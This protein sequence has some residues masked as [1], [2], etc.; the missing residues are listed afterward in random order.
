MSGRANLQ[1]TTGIPWLLLRYFLD[2]NDLCRCYCC[3]PPQLSPWHADAAVFQFQRSQIF[4][5]WL[6]SLKAK[7]RMHRCKY[8]S[9]KFRRFLFA[10]PATRN[11]LAPCISEFGSGV[12]RC[13]HFSTVCIPNYISWWSHRWPGHPWS[14]LAHHLHH[15]YHYPC[16]VYVYCA[17]SEWQRRRCHNYAQ[18]HT[19]LVLFRSIKQ[20]N[21][22]LTSDFLS[23][24]ICCKLQ[25]SS[26]PEAAAPWPKTNVWGNW[27]QALS[28]DING[29]IVMCLYLR[30]RSSHSWGNWLTGHMSVVCLL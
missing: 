19:L 11:N 26:W 21:F 18:Y 28:L 14:T 23:L 15:H 8:W 13:R 25:A 1:W 12:W 22:Y 7:D 3:V 10:G 24:E 4:S 2:T 29:E 9:S 17:E 27:S 30:L 20:I 5:N 16:Q 6:V